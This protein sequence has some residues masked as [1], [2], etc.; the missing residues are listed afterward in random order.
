MVRRLKTFFLRKRI[1]QDEVEKNFE[2]NVN[3]NMEEY[4]V[5]CNIVNILDKDDP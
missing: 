1:T 5:D 3:V 2:E 4:N